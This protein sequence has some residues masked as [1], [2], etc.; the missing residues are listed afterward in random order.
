ME[1]GWLSRRLRRADADDLQLGRLA[2]AERGLDSLVQALT[3]G[4]DCPC[5]LHGLE[6]RATDARTRLSVP[7]RD[8]YRCTDKTVR[9]TQG[10]RRDADATKN[11]LAFSNSL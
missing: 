4:H 11:P 5:Y 2:Q 3:H 10:R 7:R 6:A 1:S 9:A 8:V